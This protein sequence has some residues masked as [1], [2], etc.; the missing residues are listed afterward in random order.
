VTVAI[1]SRT[2]PS[3]VA[4]VDVRG[5]LDLDGTTALR[6]RLR[7][8]RDAGTPTRVDLS[9][10]T[11]IDS[12]GLRVLLDVA[13]DVEEHDWDCRIVAASPI[14]RRAARITGLAP[15]LPF[16]ARRVQLDRV[17]PPG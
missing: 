15:H 3:G 8:L 1:A 14:V 2:A 4:Q 5:E 12:T 17:Q 7:P 9:E 13:H 6:E 16:R 11:L 10:V